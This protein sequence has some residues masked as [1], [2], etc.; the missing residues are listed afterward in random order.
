MV[1]RIARGF[2]VFAPPDWAW[3]QGDGTFTNR[4]DDPAS[5]RG[6]PEEDRFRVI[7]CATRPA[8]AFGETIAPFRKSPRTLAGLKQVN[9]DEPLDLDLEGGIVLEDWRLEHRLGSTRLDDNLL[10]ADFTDAQAITILREALASWLVR[11]GLE[12]FDLS[13]ITSQ[14]RRVTQEAARYAYELVNSGLTVFAG[15][16]YMSRLNR[17]WELWAI[18]H[19][20]MIHTP[21]EI[22]ETIRHDAPGLV[23]AASVLDLEIE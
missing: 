1:F 16:R 12:D 11:F 2:E 5:Y 14:Q 22:S 10:F 3:A 4:F 20:R 8:G 9:D 18:F 23:Q 19:D 21:E 13:T 15:I 7:Y 6:I 17:D